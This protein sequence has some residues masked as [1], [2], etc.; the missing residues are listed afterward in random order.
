MHVH[1]PAEALVILL[2][3]TL[4]LPSAEQPKARAFP[5]RQP[6][7][8]HPPFIPLELLKPTEGE[9]HHSV[10]FTLNASSC[11]CSA[12]THGTHAATWLSAGYNAQDARLLGLE[13]DLSQRDLKLEAGEYINK[14]QVKAG[15]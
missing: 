7:R 8:D 2:R 6:G 10:L 3:F 15:S 12:P 9:P 14:A 5:A 13:R 11:R 4:Y 1:A